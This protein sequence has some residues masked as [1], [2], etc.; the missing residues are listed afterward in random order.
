MH[1]LLSLCFF[2]GGERKSFSFDSASL[3]FSSLSLKLKSS[4]RDAPACSNAGT[5]EMGGNVG[6]GGIVE[7]PN[8]DPD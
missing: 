6:G 4:Q 8:A 5:L 3:L 7:D 1:P 2:D